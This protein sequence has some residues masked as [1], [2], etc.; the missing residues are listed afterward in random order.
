MLKREKRKSC[1]KKLS[2]TMESYGKRTL[3]PRALVACVKKVQDAVA[4]V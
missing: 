4:A 1:E 2:S 3:G